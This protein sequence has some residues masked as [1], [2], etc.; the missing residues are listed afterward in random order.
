MRVYGENPYSYNDATGRNYTGNDDL[1]RDMITRMI[2]HSEHFAIVGGRRCGKTS[3]L[4]VLQRRLASSER[5][6]QQRHVV[7]LLIDASAGPVSPAILF[8]EMLRSLTS[9]IPEIS[10]SH[11][12]SIAYEEEPYRAFRTKLTS[13]SVRTA[14][15]KC[16]GRKWLG[17]VMLDE[18][19]DVAHRLLESGHGDVFFR[20]LRYLLTEEV[21]LKIHFRLVAAGVN[22][23][24]GLIRSGSPLNMLATKE[25]G[26]LR[27]E[28][29]AQLADIGF[30]G[31]MTDE[32]RSR[33]TDLT[34]RHPYLLQGVLH[35]LW[36]P[37]RVG[38]IGRQVVLA[39]DRFQREHERNFADWLS[40]FDTTARMVYG[41][42]SA[43]IGESVSLSK[44][45]RV[46]RTQGGKLIRGNEV[47]RA[48][49]VLVTHGV[50]AADTAGD[51][52][53]VSGTMFR[54]WFHSR[55]PVAQDMVVEILDQFVEHIDGL[56]LSQ[57]EKREAHDLLAKTREVFTVGGDPGEVKE[58]GG[59]TLRKMWSVVKGAKDAA[60][61][62]DMLVRLAPHLGTA[63]NWIL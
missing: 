33:L 34:G 26:I 44:L 11:W 46:L 41:Y 58:Y 42:L 29:V 14:L 38:I 43:N 24:A 30:R 36:P 8:R 60:T 19:D 4:R 1:L 37:G 32:A 7:P 9:G 61:L 63:L 6:G 2:D 53:R 22:D 3:T 28:D 48:L 17:I 57:R 59:D 20:N 47:E 35:A 62:A 56:G 49:G 55:A 31:S 51:H 15:T 12:D 18:I 5:R 39:S 21:K 13:N 27:E 25:L 45:K 23:L 16:Y 52:Y 40:V 10:E 54:G 50:V